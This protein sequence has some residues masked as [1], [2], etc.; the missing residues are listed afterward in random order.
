MKREMLIAI[1]VSLTLGLGGGYVIASNA[2]KSNDSNTEMSDHSENEGDHD[3]SSEHKE[4]HNL[5][6]VSSED[7]PTVDFTAIEDQKS[8]WNIKL[9]TG[10]F[11]FAPDNVN[12]INTIGEGHAHLY[13]DGVKVARLYGP[14]FHYGE[15]F[16]GTKEFRITLNANDHSEYSVDG[17]V[18]EATKQVTH[19]KHN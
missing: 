8:G 7:A 17:E 10:K 15:S 1:V 12:K 9:N 18:I 11:T 14:D 3:D 16:D 5:F 13:V 2:E 6:E 19:D 4:E